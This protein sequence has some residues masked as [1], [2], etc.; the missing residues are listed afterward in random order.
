MSETIIYPEKS[1]TP[2]FKS[3]LTRAC[4]QGDI[5][6][7]RACVFH[8]DFT[9]NKY[10]CETL[11]S[12]YLIACANK[13]TQIIQYLMTSPEFKPN[14]LSVRGVEVIFNNKNEEM[15]HWLIFD[16]GMNK[17]SAV[18]E[19]LIEMSDKDYAQYIESL[20]EKRALNKKLNL[21]LATGTNSKAHKI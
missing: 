20:F 5:D 8:A 11:R 19:V 7:V 6:I 2:E 13:Q 14:Q 21:E 15:I 12:A 4:R 3:E 17:S 18:E 9:K 10:S 16:Y 1:L